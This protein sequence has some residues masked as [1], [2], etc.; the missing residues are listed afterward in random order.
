MDQKVSDYQGDLPK[1]P[2]GEEAH[3]QGK[4]RQNGSG[5]CVKVDLLNE[6][7]REGAGERASVRDR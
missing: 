1:G 4:E 5:P 6:A 7:T 2:A 3:V